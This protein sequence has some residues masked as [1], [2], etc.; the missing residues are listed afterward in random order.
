[1]VDKQVH[2]V[3]HISLLT[4]A[5]HDM[6]PG[7]KPMNPPPV[8]IDSEEEWEVEEI[9]DSRFK[10]KQL[11]YL[12]KWTGTDTSEN[13]WEPDRNLKNAPEAIKEF[14]KKHP[15]APRRLR[16]TTF[17]ETSWKPLENYTL[18]SKKEEVRWILHSRDLVP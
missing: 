4:K 8:I 1:M 9:L 3:F 14:H 6:I 2:D 7:R 11:Q 13:S 17:K 16:T 15:E 5:P 18:S 12:V 10:N